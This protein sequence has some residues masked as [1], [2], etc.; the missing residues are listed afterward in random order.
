MTPLTGRRQPQAAAPRGRC[1]VLHERRALRQRHPPVSRDP[2]RPRAEQRGARR[3][4]SRPFLWVRSWRACPSAAPH[5]AVRLGEGRHRR[6]RGLAGALVLVGL[7]PSWAVL[8]AVLF[9]AGG[10]DA[11]TDVGRTPTGC[12][13]SGPT[14]ARSSTR[15]TGS[16]ASARS[17]W[18]DGRGRRSHSACRS[19]SPWS[20][21]RSSS[22]PSRS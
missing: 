15:S 1:G 3:R 18:P 7:A 10:I 16:G 20:R 4:R 9:V 19:R 13:C 6:D 17:R 12:G 2:Q 22:R 21:L 14:D 8:A 11:V 5:P